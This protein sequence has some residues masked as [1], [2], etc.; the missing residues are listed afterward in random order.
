MGPFDEVKWD[1]SGRN[2]R[3][4]VFGQTLQHAASSKRGETAVKVDATNKKE[5]GEYFVQLRGVDA[6]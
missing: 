2:K 1:V 4:W 5:R 6:K 3:R